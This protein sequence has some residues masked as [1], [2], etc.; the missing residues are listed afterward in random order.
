MIIIYHYYIKTFIPLLCIIIIRPYYKMSYLYYENDFVFILLVW[1]S[2]SFVCL[3][4]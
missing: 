2:T 1:M 3:F 4:M